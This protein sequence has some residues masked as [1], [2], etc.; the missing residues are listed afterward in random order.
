MGQKHAQIVSL[1]EVE[2]TEFGKGR[3]GFK[4]KRLA[5]PA[6][7]QAIG[8]NWFELAPKKIAF[9]YHYHAGIEEN[10]FIL[11]GCGTLRIG[12]ETVEV[13]EGDYMAF[14]AGPRFAHSL[15]NTGEKALQYLVISNKSSV[16]IV[17]YPDSKKVAVMATPDP[18]EWPPQKAWIRMII[19]E[20]PSVDYFEG[21]A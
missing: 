21:E 3:F 11:S 10:I 12:S 4:S 14:P 15:K 1:S 18:N 17:G 7:A 5:A 16:D 9:P 20:Q 13:Q 2:M 6:G 19:K 8:C